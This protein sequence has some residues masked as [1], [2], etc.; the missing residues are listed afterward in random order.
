MHDVLELTC[1]AAEALGS[2][3][4]CPNPSVAFDFNEE[5]LVHWRDEVGQPAPTP[6]EPCA[7]LPSPHESEEDSVECPVCFSLL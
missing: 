7:I 6:D 2:L 5:R 3:L 4:K 1:V